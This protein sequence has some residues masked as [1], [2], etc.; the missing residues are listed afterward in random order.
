MA[1]RARWQLLFSSGLLAAAV[2]CGGN[3]KT[4]RLFGLNRSSSNPVVTPD[5]AFQAQPPETTKTS[6]FG[7][8]FSSKSK[9]GSGIKPDTEVAFADTQAE[10]ALAEGRSPSDRDQMLDNAR[11]RYQR[12]LKDD[13]KNKGA[14]L[15]LAKLYAKMGDYPSAIGTY[16]Q[17]L[18]INPSDHAAH[19]E[20]AI[21]YGKTQDWANAVT[22]CEAA[23][24]IDHENRVYQKTLGMC[25]VRAGRYDE[26]YTVWLK[27]MP[28]AKARFFLARALEYTGKMDLVKQQ[29]QL[30]LAADPTYQPAKDYLAYLNGEQ[31]APATDTVQTGFNGGN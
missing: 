13:P 26:G 2:G 16:R 21:A 10:A 3:D 20:L 25:L 18:D 31:A 17:Y 12:A 1:R 19:H 28:E 7:D 4:P 15:G 11:Q 24:A 5:P 23:L 9:T 14:F 30:C 6:F 8:A 22:S 27:V 29:V